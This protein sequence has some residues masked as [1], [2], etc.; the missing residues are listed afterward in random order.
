MISESLIKRLRACRSLPTP[1]AVATRIID[2]ANDPQVD[3]DQIAQ[4]L[5]SDPATTAKVLRIANSPM[6][7]MSREVGNL[8]QALM[9]LG[10][11]A[12][13]SLA[14][15]FSLLKSFQKKNAGAGLDYS[16][17]WKRALIAASATR[18]ISAKLGFRDS[19]EMF[20][21]ALIQDIGV[22]ALDSAYPDLYA[23]LGKDQVH[24][25][26]LISAENAKT[27]SDHA[28]VGA[29]LLEEWRF[30]ERAKLAVAGSHA[31]EQANAK[32]EDGV[33]VRAVAFSNELAELFLA[34]SDE[35]RLPE[36]ADVALRYL[37]VDKEGLGEM[38]A[39]VGDMIP[40]AEAVFEISLVT[41]ADA[42][43]ILE[44][45]RE[46]LMLRNLLALKAV[47]KLEKTTEE[48]TNR[49][50][51]LEQASQR[52]SL[53][54]LYNRAFLEQHLAQAFEACNRNNLP[55]SI[56]FADLDRFK[57]VNDRHGHMA[58]DQVLV[59][60]ANVLK[61]N[62]RQSDV[63]GR[64]GGEEFIL[65]F[66]ETDFMLVKAICERITRAIGATRHD[67]E[68]ASLPVTISMG[69]ATHNDGRRFANVTELIAAADKALYSAKLQ[70]RNRNIPFD[71][72]ADAKSLAV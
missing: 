8:S 70:G 15:S 55:L 19:E 45:A 34:P 63:V 26:I 17:F 28:E 12:T 7:A 29:W 36:L 25:S 3:M 67:V 41:R 49:T 60:I 38:I 27:G 22:L 30:P 20:L 31:P 62:V 50:K 69:L 54:G 59:T 44:E 33:F 68:G 24:Q 9:I 64:Y 72:I 10:L 2:L 43:A 32:G 47:D 51:A 4:V 5:S 42:E 37:G 35:R 6:Y 18:A 14:L 66:P 1:P 58:G 40:N 57:S 65:V 53:T 71:S 13:I 48:L 23:G 61:A 52:D 11:N 46:S 56:A 16:L 39:E 21:A